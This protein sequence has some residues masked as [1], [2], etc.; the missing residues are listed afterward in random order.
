MRTQIFE[1]LGMSRTTFDFARAQKSNHARPH[2]LDVDGKLAIGKMDL[3]YAVVPVRPAGGMWTSVHDLSRYVMM[4]LA[5]GRLSD[6]SRL[7][8]EQNLVM[9]R[10]PQILLG[11]DQTYGMGLMED[12]TWGVNVVHHGGDL[13]GYHSDMIFLP[14][15]GVGAV[16]LTNSD[17][18]VRLRRPF[19]RRLLEV[20][21]DGKP[22][23]AEDL[24]ASARQMKAEIAK[25][26]ERLIVPADP[27]QAA[28]LAARY[29][30]AALGDVVV[31]H[32]RGGTVFD[33]GEWKSA[34]ASRVNDDH[35]ISFITTDPSLLG[36]EFVVADRD[37]KR[38]L[39]VRD[40]QHEYVF[41]ETADRSQEQE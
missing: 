40:G 32:E 10:S 34:V 8:S 29:R 26:R 38:A 30:N 18:G 2:G 22:E 16:I 27:S 17:P 25:E 37:G 3:N 12:R 35:T 5:G 7:V 33:V 31:R 1:P 11:E 19:M 24:A 39:I 6:G 36:F 14:V 23:A 4:E 28:K 20:L 21:F 41:A 13:A 9:R 15:H